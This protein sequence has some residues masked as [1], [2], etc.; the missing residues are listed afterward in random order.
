M[1][2]GYA[3]FRSGSIADQ[4]HQGPVL[5]C[6]EFAVLAAHIS[7]PQICVREMCTAAMHCAS[8]LGLWAQTLDACVRRGRE[9]V[10]QGLSISLLRAAASACKG[11]QHLAISSKAIMYSQ[12]DEVGAAPAPAQ[13]P[14]P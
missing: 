14:F 4:A 5:W 11:L 10:D 3:A 9:H 2:A 8:T 12:F 13:P 7:A 1:L 6:R